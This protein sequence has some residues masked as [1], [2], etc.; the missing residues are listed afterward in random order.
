LTRFRKWKYSAGIGT[1]A[2]AEPGS[3]IDSLGF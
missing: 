3:A 2:A 1:Q